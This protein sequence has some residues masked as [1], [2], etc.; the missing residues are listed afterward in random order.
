MEALSQRVYASAAEQRAA[1]VDELNDVA[2]RAQA[3]L[4]VLTRRTSST[5]RGDC[6]S[7][8]QRGQRFG[9]GR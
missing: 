8:V 7:A 4:R 9:R 1:V 3:P 5:G 6:L 2:Q